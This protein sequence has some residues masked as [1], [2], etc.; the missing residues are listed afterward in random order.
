MVAIGYLK[1]SHNRIEKD[2]YHRVQQAIALVY[3][4]FAE[5]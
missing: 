5:L 4:K 3:A 1:T 2:P